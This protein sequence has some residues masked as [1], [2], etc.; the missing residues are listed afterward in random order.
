MYDIIVLMKMSDNA[1][2]PGG[3]MDEASD[4]IIKLLT[5]LSMA[6]V[7]TKFNK[8]TGAWEE[9]GTFT[10]ISRQLRGDS[11]SDVTLMIKTVCE[12][13]PQV[14]DRDT[15]EKIKPYI[16]KAINGIDNISITYSD[17]NSLVET[18]KIYIELMKEYR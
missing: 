11:R 3:L 4:R 17:T 16:K 18:L 10:C 9:Q 7:G 2:K 8:K 5:I 14:A 6:I 12:L 15:L 1:Q 13:L